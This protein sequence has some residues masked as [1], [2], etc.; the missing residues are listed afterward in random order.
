MSTD[1][2]KPARNGVQNEA[3]TLLMDE[4]AEVIQAAAK[5]QR[6]GAKTINTETSIANDIALTKKLADLNAVIQLAEEHGALTPPIE[7]QIAQAI[8]RKRE[9]SSL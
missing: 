9:Y 7:K 4:C 1:Q 5:I 8:A 6:F 2:T 3:L